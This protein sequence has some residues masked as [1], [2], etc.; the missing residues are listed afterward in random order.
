MEVNLWIIGFVILLTLVIGG[1]IGWFLLGRRPARLDPRHERLVRSLADLH[2]N[3]PREAIEIMARALVRGGL[4]WEA[5]VQARVLGGVPGSGSSGQ[6]S[7]RQPLSEDTDR[8]GATPRDAR[9]Q[10]GGSSAAKNV[11][12]P[13]AKSGPQTEGPSPDGARDEDGGSG[14]KGG[15]DRH[16][17]RRRRHRSKESARRPRS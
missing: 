17:R 5:D 4:V 6:R 15:A 3:N 2:R 8:S 7:S 10:Q 14:A 13:P 16:P 1:I 9:G 12:G 11:Q